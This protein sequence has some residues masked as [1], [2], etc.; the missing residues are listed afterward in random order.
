MSDNLGEKL[1]LK[2]PI[3]TLINEL[4]IPIVFRLKQTLLLQNIKI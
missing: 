3:P 4:N 2:N 1:H